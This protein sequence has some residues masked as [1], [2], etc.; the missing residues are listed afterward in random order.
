MKLCGT[1]AGVWLIPSYFFEG[2]LMR[3]F[4]QKEK[5]SYLRT[6]RAMMSIACPGVISRLWPDRP[7]MVVLLIVT[8]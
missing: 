3:G 5:K 4:R 6:N 1:F 2:A 7:P 8:V